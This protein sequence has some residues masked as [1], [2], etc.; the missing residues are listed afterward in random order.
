LNNFVDG[1]PNNTITCW[2]TNFKNERFPSST[3]YNIFISAG[4][5]SSPGPPT[6]GA[7]TSD[8]TGIRVSSTVSAPTFVDQTN[9]NDVTNTIINYKITASS[10][11]DS[12]YRYGGPVADNVSFTSNSRTI[13]MTKL[14]PNSSYSFYAQAQNSTTN[15]AYGANSSTRFLTT[16]SLAI[17][18]SSTI[19][20]FYLF[21]SAVSAKLIGS[22]F[23][24]SAN[25]P[26]SKLLFTIPTTIPSSSSFTNSIHNSL[27]NGSTGNN[28]LTVNVALKKDNITFDTLNVDYN[29]FPAR[30]PGS[31]GNIN[32]SINTTLPTDG[33]SGNGLT[34][35]YLNA[36]N[37]ITLKTPVFVSSN[38]RNYINA[39]VSRHFPDALVGDYSDYFYYDLYSGLPSFNNSESNM[40]LRTTN[41]IQI[42]GIWIVYGSIGLTATTSVNNIGNYFYNSTRILSYSSGQMEINTANITSGKNISSFTNPV[43]F[44]NSTIT[45]LV[46]SF[47]NSISLNVNAYGLT[48]TAVNLVYNNISMI[49]DAPTYSL[50]SGATPKYPLSVNTI[51]RSPTQYG[52]RVPTGVIDSSQFSN[53]SGNFL[54]PLPPSVVYS[55]TPY[56]Q[57]ESLVSNRELQLCAGFYQTKQGSSN[58]YLDYTPYFYNPTQK[59][60]FNYSS[61]STSEYRFATFSFRVATGASYQ[62]IR[63]IINDIQ[64]TLTFTND[65]VTKPTIGGE[66]L[67]FYYR[68]E[69]KN[70]S[71]QLSDYS[72]ANNNTTWLD[73]TDTTMTPVN[74]SNFATITNIFSAG[75]GG[76][77]HVYNNS[78]KT[79]TINSVCRSLTV[80]SSDEIYIYFRVCAP[81]N[82]TFSFSSVSAQFT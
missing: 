51:S 10:L 6:F 40:S 66:R 32:M 37:S 38:K 69:D 19:T 43:I 79:Y 18:P 3:S 28:L 39:T 31:V 72:L 48:N 53:N 73:A 57:T 22:N 82:K 7:Q 63:F 30:N 9:T 77:L 15:K 20:N 75:D 41:S 24:D 78:L 11:G 5:P 62:L 55:I 60:T 1:D 74:D 27:T 13:N 45:T 34:G 70:N 61:I 58:G 2:Y 23:Y 81:M 35:Y 44:S 76:K 4:T 29:G 25:A 8:S 36:S 67:Y 56:D 49:L 12:V 21:P 68:V 16:D 52:F 71:S 80:A 33:Y 64:Q 46:S 42:C 54:S 47:A 65:D 50:I 14:F 17:P 26:V 59:N